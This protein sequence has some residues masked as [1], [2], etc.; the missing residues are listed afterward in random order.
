MPLIKSFNFY[1]QTLKRFYF[2]KLV[3]VIF[4]PVVVLSP[5]MKTFAAAEKN[6]SL[7]MAT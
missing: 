5:L 2:L 4:N 6:A 7:N 1:L 3:D